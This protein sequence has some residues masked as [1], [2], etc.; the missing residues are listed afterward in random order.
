M[1]VR[2]L[3]VDDVPTA[4]AILRR[5]LEAIGCEIV[6]EAD[7]SAAADEVMETAAPDLIT[8]DIQMPEIGG[9]DAYTL[10]R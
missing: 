6:A 3:I 2:T 8:L 1:A 5:R 4:R 10:F 7:S 9:M